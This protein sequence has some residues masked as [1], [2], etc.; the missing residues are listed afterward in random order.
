[1]RLVA[2]L[3]LGLI[4]STGA[5]ALTTSPSAFRLENKKNGTLLIGSGFALIESGETYRT[6]LLLWGKLEVDGTVEEIL[7]LSGHVTFHQGARL[8]KSLTLM[9]GSYEIQPGAEVKNESI[10]IRAPGVFWRLLLTAGD[11]W[12]EHFRG[13]VVV[14]FNFVWCMLLWAFSY[15][16]FRSFPGLQKKIS[17][18]LLESWPKNLI[19]G[20]VGSVAVPAL[21]GLLVISIFGIMVLPLYLLLLLAAAVLSYAGAVGWAGHRILPPKAGKQLRGV[22]LLVG[23]VALQLFWVS[24]VWWAVL[25]ALFLWTLAWGALLRGARGIWK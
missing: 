3:L 20:L 24:G 11:F 1:M 15:V 19:A 22:S 23:V 2:A 21:F 7:V 17:A 10:S 25:P 18:S 8:T 9:G 5:Q 14:A 6:V 12:E 4:F 16:I 13:I